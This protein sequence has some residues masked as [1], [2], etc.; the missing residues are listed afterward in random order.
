VTIPFIT[1]IATTSGSSSYYFGLGNS[2]DISVTITGLDKFT[3]T[4]SNAYG[5]TYTYNFTVNMM[6]LTNQTLQ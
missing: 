6:I 3:I 5:V 1:E 2:E 4:A